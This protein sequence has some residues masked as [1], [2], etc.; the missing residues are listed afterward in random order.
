[1]GYIVFSFLSDSFS[2]FFSTP[3]VSDNVPP[4]PFL[5]A[6]RTARHSSSQE[7]VLMAIITLAQFDSPITIGTTIGR[8]GGI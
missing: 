8:I 1:M 5:A 2:V 7:L 3:F 6:R 4:P